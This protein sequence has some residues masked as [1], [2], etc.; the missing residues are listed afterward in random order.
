MKKN[1]KNPLTPSAVIMLADISI[2]QN[3]MNDA[4]I[5]IDKTLKNSEKYDSRTLELMK[6]RILLGQNKTRECIH[7]A[8][9]IISQ[10]SLKPF[11][12]KVPR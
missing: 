9:K 6:A 11:A 3:K 7:I 2:N 10:N 5:M 12:G 4:L 1:P 8:R